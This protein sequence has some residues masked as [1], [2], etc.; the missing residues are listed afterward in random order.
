MPGCWRRLWCGRRGEAEGEGNGQ[1][2]EGSGREISEVGQPEKIGADE[3][4]PSEAGE[5]KKGKFEGPGEERPA[6]P[7]GG[8][9]PVGGDEGKNKGGERFEAL[10]AETVAAE[11]PEDEEGER[12]GEDEVEQFGGE[13]PAG[14]PEC[15][16]NAKAEDRA[17]LAPEAAAG[18]HGPAGAAVDPVVEPIKG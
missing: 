11:T 6:E 5:A 18:V 7:A 1:P 15:D 16:G 13:G 8:G 3:F 14:S 12:G 9:I 4:G 2:N 17:K 10:A